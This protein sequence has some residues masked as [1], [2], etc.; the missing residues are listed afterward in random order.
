MKLL[1]WLL[2]VATCLCHARP[3][4]AA[5]P[6]TSST[7]LRDVSAAG[8]LEWPTT[9]TTTTTKTKTA[10]T[11][12]KLT[13][14]DAVQTAT[15]LAGAFSSKDPHSWARALGMPKFLDAASL[16]DDYI[17]RRLVSPELGGFGAFVGSTLVGA[18]VLE[19]ARTPGSWND[20]FH[21]V[22]TGNTLSSYTQSSMEAIV[23]R[24]KAIFHEEFLRRQRG[25]RAAGDA[26]AYSVE[27]RV[28]FF[29]WLAADRQVR[30][31][32]VASSLVTQ[33]VRHVRRTG[34]THAL[35]FASNPSSAR[36]FVKAGFEKWGEV[37][38]CLSPW[39]TSRG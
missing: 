7:A 28:A 12:A 2:V 24:C 1:A 34:H 23:H 35:A 5:R 8:T 6:R 4:P 19:R 33:A 39:P 38:V 31:N 11:Y 18:V 16:A 3:L 37:R 30:G 13:A 9:T 21:P 32:G 20:D 15:C 22:F 26:L 27:S 25:E 14:E 29:A 10:M 36:A 17:P